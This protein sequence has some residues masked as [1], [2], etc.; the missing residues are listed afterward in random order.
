MP[1]RIN[2]HMNDEVKRIRE[3]MGLTQ[4]SLARLIGVTQATVSRWESGKLPVDTRTMLA[5]KTL[6]AARAAA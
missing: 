1:L 5:L 4:D 3:S 6:Q 2:A